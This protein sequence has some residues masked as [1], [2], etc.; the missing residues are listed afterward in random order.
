[1]GEPSKTPHLHVGS[2]CRTTAFY[3]AR[4]CFCVALSL[5]S[6]V[7]STCARHSRWIIR[8]CPFTKSKLRSFTCLHEQVGLQDCSAKQTAHPRNRRTRVV[9]S[10]LFNPI[11]F[12][13][14]VTFVGTICPSVLHYFPDIEAI[15]FLVILFCAKICWIIDGT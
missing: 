14:T 11:G 8:Q 12:C 7:G 1:M 2:F 9:G 13:V 5:D 15:S 10:L 6:L 3:F 4:L